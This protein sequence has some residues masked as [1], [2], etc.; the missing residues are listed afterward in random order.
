[1]ARSL[2]QCW[3]QAAE[4]A[5]RFISGSSNVNNVADMRGLGIEQPTQGQRTNS[6][7]HPSVVGKRAPVSEYRLGRQKN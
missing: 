2:L 7:F 1:M 6:A 3:P 5:S 4:L